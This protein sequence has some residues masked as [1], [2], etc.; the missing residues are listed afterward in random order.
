MS[1]GHPKKEKPAIKEHEYNRLIFQC[2][3]VCV[4]VCANAVIMSIFIKYY[5]FIRSEY[6]LHLFI[7]NAYKEEKRSL[8][9][10]GCSCI[11]LSQSPSPK[12]YRSPQMDNEIKWIFFA[13]FLLFKCSN[14]DLFNCRILSPAFDI[15]IPSTNQENRIMFL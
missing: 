15:Q 1:F 13:R 8:L 12:R 2:L 3:V 14:A 11:H 4:C 6:R 9:D 7:S 5:A 10:C